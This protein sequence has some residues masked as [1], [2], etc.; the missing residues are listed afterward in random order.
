[1]HAH[2]AALIRHAAYEQPPGVPSAH[3]LH[4]LT[5]EGELQAQGIG[6]ALRALASQLDC[7]IDPVIDTSPL[8]RAYQTA[9]IA[10]EDLSKRLGATVGVSEHVELCERCL[11]ACANLTTDEVR[12]QLSRD[13]RRPA[14]LED[15][16]T[17]TDFALPVPGAESLRAAGWRVAQHLQAR[18]RELAA[19]AHAPTLKLFVGHG[20]AFRHAAYALGVLPLARV[21][22]LSMHHARPVVLKQSPDGG[23]MHVAGA[24]KER[25]NATAND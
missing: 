12:A 13:P 4:P 11:G 18:M 16:K 3:L 21:S 17:S 23:F 14:L 20:A 19:L 9:N 7:A 6:E 15:W 10:A 24:W 2:F 22:M 8:L 25:G 1:M 5:R